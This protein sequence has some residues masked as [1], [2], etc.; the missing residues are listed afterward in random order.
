MIAADRTSV[1]RHVMQ[2]DDCDLRERIKILASEP[3]GSGYR[4]LHILL[5]HERHGVNR[6]RV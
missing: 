4:R 1:R 3:R 6:K 5:Q 2:P